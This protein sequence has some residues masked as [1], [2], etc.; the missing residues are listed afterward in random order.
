MKVRKFV[1]L[2]TIIGAFAVMLIETFTGY[3]V[4]PN[5]FQAIVYVG[6]GG[7]AAVGIS[8]YWKKN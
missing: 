2:A 5:K 4:D 1:P 7:S 6:L 8:R 3:E